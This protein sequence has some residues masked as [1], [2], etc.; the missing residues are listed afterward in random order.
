MKFG[1][2][3]MTT[4]MRELG[5]PQARF[6][7]TLVAGTNGKGSVTAMT[8]SILR[9]AGFRTGRYTSP[10]LV[11]LE[12]RFVVDGR[13]VD[14]PKLA[15][16]VAAV[17][18]AVGAL[19]ADGEFGA[20]ATFFECATAAAFQLFADEELDVAVLEVGLGGRLDAT[21]VVTPLVGAIT[22]IDYDHQAQLGS[23][24][25]EIAAEKAGIIKPGVPLI[26]GRIPSGAQAVIDGIAERMGAPVIRALDSAVIPAGTRL[27]LAGQHQ[28]DN[29]LVAVA[30][31]DALRT[32]GF[33]T[34][35]QAVRAG[36]ERVRWPGRLE[37]VRHGTCDVLLDAAH[38]PAG[39]QAL[40][41]YLREIGWTG[42]TLVFGAMSD[43]DCARMLQVLAPVVGRIVFTT[44]PTPRAEP[45]LSLSRIAAAAAVTNRIEIV[46]A[47]GDALTHACAGSDTVVVAGSMFLI[48]PLRDILR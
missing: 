19:I 45:A 35:E 42:A 5:E 3:N 31:T 27:A 47:P 36:L 44:A 13:E 18:D 2:E 30:M 22:T 12:E 28:H 8:E 33:P 1:L 4:L 6:P 40:A 46:E 14:T 26:T 7:S 17:R 24:I 10:H 48:G 23:T 16:A 29:A 21:N 39:A 41:N 38:T 37:H 15:A 11:R 34:A 43:K 9:S 20:P 32:R 25:E